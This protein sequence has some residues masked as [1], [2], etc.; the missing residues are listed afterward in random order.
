MT[1][2][3]FAK[4]FFNQNLLQIKLTFYWRSFFKSS[5]LDR[6]IRISRHIE[7]VSL[8]D[9][10]GISVQAFYYGRGWPIFNTNLEDL[11]L[12]LTLLIFYI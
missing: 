5:Y 1:K 8:S 4:I 9:G 10:L 3:K 2:I 6:L 12:N 11:L 7:H